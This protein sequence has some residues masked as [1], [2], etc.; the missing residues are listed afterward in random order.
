[1]FYLTQTGEVV[2]SSSNQRV[3]IQAPAN[4]QMWVSLNFIGNHLFASGYVSESGAVLYL[5]KEN[6]T[7]C[8]FL[9]FGSICKGQ[10]YFGDDVP[11]LVIFAPILDMIPIVHNGKTLIVC[12]RTHDLDIVEVVND[13]LVKVNSQRVRQG[14][15]EDTITNLMLM[16]DGKSLITGIRHYKKKGSEFAIAIYRL[17][18]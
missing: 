15:D 9:R 1:M 2:N 13:Q 17:V 10:C 4:L 7:V 6:L 5:L 12:N 14:T 3:R 18:Q 11:D 8:N 16:K